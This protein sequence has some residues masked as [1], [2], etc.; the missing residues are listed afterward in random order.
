MTIPNEVISFFKDQGFVVV[1]TISQDGSLHNS[2]KDVLK[3]EKEGSVYLLD[4]YLRNTFQNL[5]I[6]PNISITAVDEHRFIGYSLVGKAKIVHD[7]KLNR[8]IFKAWEQ[9]MTSR[10][11]KRIIKNLKGEKGHKLHPEAA[12][13]RPE[14]LIVMDVTE[15][16]DLTPVHLK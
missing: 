3:I 4:L 14:Y 7:E 13:P 5:K 15:V 16:I 11:S 1:S 6:N 10:I 8:D 12:L 2:C 9:K